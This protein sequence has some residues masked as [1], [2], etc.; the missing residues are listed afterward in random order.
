VP[1]FAYLQAPEDAMQ[2]VPITFINCI[3]LHLLGIGKVIMVWYIW[4]A[5]LSHERSAHFGHV[6]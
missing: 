5:G 2:A 6:P 3:L 4:G 1:S